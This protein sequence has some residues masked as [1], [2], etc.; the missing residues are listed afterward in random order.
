MT[1]YVKVKDVVE[2]INGLD[3]LPFEEETEEL[4]NQLPIYTDN[5]IKEPKDRAKAG[6]DNV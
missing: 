4:V 1:K 5:V 3:S 2:L 6:R